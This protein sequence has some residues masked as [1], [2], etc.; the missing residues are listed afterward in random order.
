VDEALAARVDVEAIYVGRDDLGYDGRGVPV[1]RLAPGVVERVATTTH[2]QPVLA[3]VRMPPAPADVLRSAD[4]VLAVD[5]VGDPGNL[6]TM[7]RS[8]EAAGVDAVAVSDGAVDPYN[9]KVVRASAGALFHVAVLTGVD[10][11]ALGAY[12]LRLVGTSPHRGIDYTDAD[13]SGRLAVVFGS[14][15][16]GL[17]AGTRVDEWVRVP[18]AGR[19]ESLNVAMAATLVLFEA[20]RR[21]TRFRADETDG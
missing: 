2:A 16:H 18:H 9:P 20:A 10:L 4:F 3:V 1:H 13:F 6:G 14:E 21:R 17:D 12:G 19:A 5:R 11:S 7:L 15:A 8:A